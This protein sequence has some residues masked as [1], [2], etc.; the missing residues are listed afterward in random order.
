MLNEAAMETSR[1]FL[2]DKFYPNRLSLQQKFQAF[3]AGVN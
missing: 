2:C 1:L 3:L